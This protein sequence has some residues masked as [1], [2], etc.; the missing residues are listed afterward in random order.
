MPLTDEQID[1]F[2]RQILVPEIG[3]RGQQRLLE[4]RVVI[5][6]QSEPLVVTRRY[7]QATGLNVSG[8]TQAQ[9]AALL[10]VQQG[11]VDDLRSFVGHALETPMVLVGSSDNTGWYTRG[12]TAVDCINCTIEC[13]PTV[14]A[15][16]PATRLPIALPLGNAIAIDAIK[17]VLGLARGPATVVRLSDGGNQRTVAPLPRSC[18]CDA[19]Q[20]ERE[21]VAG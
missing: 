5:F 1:R 18:T 10:L 20:L 6:G 7:L 19:P 12:I 2:S 16:D 15:T 11:C 4:S 8:A 14:P 17:E 9:D 13:C 21:R 3:G